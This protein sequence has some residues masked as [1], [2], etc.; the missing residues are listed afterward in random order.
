MEVGEGR[1]QALSQQSVAPRKWNDYLVWSSGKGPMPS[2]ARTV[3][4]Q[5]TEAGGPF[6]GSLYPLV[7][8]APL[9][10]STEGIEFR[11]RVCA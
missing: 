3:W 6:L 2:L 11:L 1:G 4:Q 9:L 10:K 7:L 8:S 5:H